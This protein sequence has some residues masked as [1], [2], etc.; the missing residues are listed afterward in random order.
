MEKFPKKLSLCYKTVSKGGILE[1]LN[2]EPFKDPITQLLNKKE[3]VEIILK[4]HKENLFRFLY[5]NWRTIHDKLYSEDYTIDLDDDKYYISYDL[6]DLFYIDL[7]IMNYEETKEFNYSLKFIQN[8]NN[9]QKSI[10]G[11]NKYKK[12]IY[13]KI[14][15]D[16]INYIIK[17]GDVDEVEQEILDDLKISNENIIEKSLNEIKNSFKGIDNYFSEEEIF[18][19]DEIYSFL[20]ICII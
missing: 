10:G 2:D 4:S 9:I 7:I 12:L 17:T 19:I 20:K 11:E 8:I 1:N 14:I 3:E 15:I 18:K 6:S 5:F 16:L 13:A